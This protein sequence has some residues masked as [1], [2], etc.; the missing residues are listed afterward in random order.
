MVFCKRVFSSIYRERNRFKTIY[1]D[2]ICSEKDLENPEKVCQKIVQKTD[3][4]IAQKRKE[5]LGCCRLG[6]RPG[7]STTSSA[8]KEPLA[9]VDRSGRP[10]SKRKRSVLRAVDPGTFD[11]IEWPPDVRPAIDRQLAE[12]AAS[13]ERVRASLG[14]IVAVTIVGLGLLLVVLALVLLLT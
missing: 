3:F 13:R 10:S 4:R 5:P 11:G 6:G 1:L 8:G 9:R 2:L 7:R 14:R 12:A